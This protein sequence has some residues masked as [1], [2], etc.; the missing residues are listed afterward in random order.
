[1]ESGKFNSLLG[2]LEIILQLI[3]S[4]LSIELFPRNCVLDFFVIGL[5]VLCPKNFK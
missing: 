3:V 2:N 4:D 5:R 1:M